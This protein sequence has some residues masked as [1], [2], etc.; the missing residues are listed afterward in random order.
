MFQLTKF[1]LFN[2]CAIEMLF[3]RPPKRQCHG[4]LA[5]QK[6]NIEWK[7][8]IRR[9]NVHLKM[10]CIQNPSWIK[11][12]LNIH[13]YRDRNVFQ[14]GFTKCTNYYYILFTIGSCS[15]NFRFEKFAQWIS[16]PSNLDDYAIARKRILFK[17]S[18]FILNWALKVWEIKFGNEFSLF[19]WAVYKLQWSKKYFG[20]GYCIF[21]GKIERSISHD[22]QNI[23]VKSKP[24]FLY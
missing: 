10:N 9:K 14:M 12:G 20:I 24:K 4:A 21:A 2:F 6:I 7:W 18:K 19:D 16:H 5:L 8:K 22:I 1:L 3:R 17:R 23:V 11:I 13:Y 15:L